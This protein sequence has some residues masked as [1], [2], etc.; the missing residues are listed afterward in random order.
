MADVDQL[1][2]AELVEIRPVD[3][4]DADAQFRLREYFVELDRRFDARF[5]PASSSSLELDELR[6]PAGV[7]LVAILRAEPVACG[8]L[9]FHGDEPAELKRMWVAESARGLGREIE[10]FNDEPY[11]HYWFEKQLPQPPTTVPGTATE[12]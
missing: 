10:A 2:T 3:P 8:A 6:P 12:V 7:F 5:D 4:A 11:A 9:K 1:L